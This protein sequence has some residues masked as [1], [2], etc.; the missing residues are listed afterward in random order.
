[1]SQRLWQRGLCRAAQP[2]DSSGAPG[3]PPWKARQIPSSVPIRLRG[4][5]HRVTGEIA[6]EGSGEASVRGVSAFWF[7]FLAFVPEFRTGTRAARQRLFQHGAHQVPGEA[8][9]MTP[10]PEPARTHKHSHLAQINTGS[11]PSELLHSLSQAA[12]GCRSF[13]PVLWRDNKCSRSWDWAGM[14]Q[15]SH[16]NQ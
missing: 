16:W 9:E 2:G 14:S 8:G 12:L 6:L 3:K 1:M 10:C 13:L 4:G 11:F 5:K 15:G 7:I